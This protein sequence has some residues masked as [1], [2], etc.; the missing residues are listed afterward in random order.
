MNAVTRRQRIL[1][2]LSAEGECPV[3][4]LATLLAV[5]QMTQDAQRRSDA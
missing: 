3:A 5:S 1:E 2:R 4:R